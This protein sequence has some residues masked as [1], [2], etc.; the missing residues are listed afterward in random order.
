[1]KHIS[2]LVL[3]LS[4]FAFSNLANA[5]SST[6]NEA[7]SIAVKKMGLKSS[8][9]Q[10]S[11]K[12][13]YTG[14]KIVSITTLKEAITEN[15]DGSRTFKFKVDGIDDA[16][17]LE[18][19]VDYLNKAKGISSVDMKLVSGR[20]YSGSMDLASIVTKDVLQENFK[21]FGVIE[22]ITNK[23]TIKVQ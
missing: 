6:S 23:K 21:R 5:Q 3:V 11:S 4:S 9:T 13:I 15:K 1:M 19:F 14:D 7:T 10:V 8:G 2:L 16:K 22:I 12:K 20:I 18:E 17:E